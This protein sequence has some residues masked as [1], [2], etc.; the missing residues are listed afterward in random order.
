M[1]NVK[2]KKDNA[3]V[4]IVFVLM[5]IVLGFHIYTGYSNILAEIVFW[6]IF[7]F[8]SWSTLKAIYIKLSGEFVD[9]MEMT[10]PTAISAYICLGL[11]FYILYHTNLYFFVTYG[12][13]FLLD[14]VLKRPK[15]KSQ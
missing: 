2:H 11:V 5:N 7:A 14:V 15:S 3:S 12:I 9:L 10:W 4:T 13:L 1:K 6:L 8:F